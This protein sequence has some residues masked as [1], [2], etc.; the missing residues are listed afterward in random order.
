[1]MGGVFLSEANQK[2]Q[3]RQTAYKVWIKNV[4]DSRYM[5]TE[6]LNPNYLEINGKEV[7]RVNIIGAVVEKSEINDRQSLVLDDGSGK[8]SVMDFEN[9]ALLDRLD[10]GN[11]VLIIGKPREFSSEKYLLIETIKKVDDEWA[12]VR[13]LELGNIKAYK[14][15]SSL[16]DSEP[17]KRED[18]ESLKNQILKLIKGLDKGE[19]VSIEDIPPEQ[20]KD[21]DKIVNVL[22]KE[23]DVFEIKPGK[24]K[25]LE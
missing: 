14:E 7:S 2:F 24:L 16:R 18:L 20:F 8:L 5:K 1:M 19:G 3:K 4:I 12:K 25:V 13:V 22:L 6:G 15:N 9:R 17:G 11:I 10:V 23:G 21:V